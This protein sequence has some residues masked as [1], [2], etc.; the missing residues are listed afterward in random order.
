MQHRKRMAAVAGLSLA[1]IVLAAISET[2]AD[3]EVPIIV[4]KDIA[5]AVN[6]MADE[7]GKGGN[8][9]KPSEEFFKKHE[10]DLKKTMYVFKPRKEKGEGGFGVGKPGQYTPDGIEGVIITHGKKILTEKQLK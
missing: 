10:A 4:P 5:E 3:D 1:L 7:A 2:I 8:L 6:K 9:K